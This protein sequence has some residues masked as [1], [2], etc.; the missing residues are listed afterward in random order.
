MRCACP[1]ALPLLCALL[2]GGC[3][4]WVPSAAASVNVEARPPAHVL[5]LCACCPAPA[6]MRL[7][8]HSHHL[9]KS[10]NVFFT[11]RQRRRR[12]HKSD[13][14]DGTLFAIFQYPRG[15]VGYVM[16]A[17]SRANGP[18]SRGRTSSSNYCFGIGNG[19]AIDIVIMLILGVI[20]IGAFT[21]TWMEL[22]N[23]QTPP[24]S[25]LWASF[26][27]SFTT[28]SENQALLTSTHVTTKEI[29]SGYGNRSNKKINNNTKSSPPREKPNVS[30]TT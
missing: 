22:Q 10:I 21:Y 7:L 23:P 29:V 19:G 3:C 25:A 11:R 20:S 28:A 24:L 5:L 1:A 12:D 17:L 4:G 26:T 16:N 9:L 27:L 30:T 18:T 8:R 6:V 13:S 15:G 14:P 2:G